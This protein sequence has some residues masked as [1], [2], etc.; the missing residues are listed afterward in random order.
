MLTSR[1]VPSL[2][3][4]NC[5]QRLFCTIYGPQLVGVSSFW[6]RPNFFMPYVWGCLCACASTSLTVCWRW[7]IITLQGFHLRAWSRSSTFRLWQIYLLSP[8]WEYRT[9]LAVRLQWSLMPSC[10]MKVKMKL[11]SLLHF[12]LSYLPKLHCL[13]LLLCLHNMTLDL[14]RLWLHWALFRGMS[15]LFSERSALSVL[16]LSNAS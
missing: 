1:L 3:R 2:P 15:A 6:R 9:L 10:G 4:T 12:S 8:R 16:E 5:F 7:E 11:L 14:L 13:R